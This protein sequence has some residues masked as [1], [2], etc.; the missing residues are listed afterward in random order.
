MKKIFGIIAFIFVATMLIGC[1]N[2]TVNEATVDT[3]DVDSVVVS[4]SVASDTLNT[5]N[6][7]I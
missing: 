2:K 1:G 7:S 3:I 4:D 5:V 6:D